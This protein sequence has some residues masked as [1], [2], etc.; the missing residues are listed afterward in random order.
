MNAIFTEGGFGQ[1]IEWFR[2][3]EQLLIAM[4]PWVL[5]GVAII[6]FVESGVLFPVLPGDSLIF[7]AGLL[8]TQ[9]GINMWVLII[10]ILVT[11]FLG[12]QVGYWIGRRWGRR[13]FKP[14]AR[15]LKT[16]YLDQ[17][18]KFFARYGGR[19]LVLGRFVP[20]VRTFVPLAAGAARL[21]YGKFLFFNTLGALVWGAGIT[22]AG[23]ALGG[24]D[25]VHDNLEIIV[26]LIVLVSVIP[27]VVEYVLHKRRKAREPQE[28]TV[29][30]DVVVEED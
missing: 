17:A 5:V 1:L 18:E 3:P 30:V 20:F 14:D 9:L 27:M 4:G 19:A 8:H 2:D 10:T 28:E 23:A 15:I 7:A 24:I 26:I 13:L 21:P 11:A 29:D 25:F 12:A 6:V 16:Q 22:W